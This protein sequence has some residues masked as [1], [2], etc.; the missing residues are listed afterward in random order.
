MFLESRSDHVLFAQNP[1]T[2]VPF[3]LKESQSNTLALRS[4]MISQSVTSLILPVAILLLAFIILPLPSLLLLPYKNVPALSSVYVT[5]CLGILFA[6]SL[7]SFESF[8]K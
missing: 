2:V 4:Y 7:K 8:P 5:H 3:L 6:N 1:A